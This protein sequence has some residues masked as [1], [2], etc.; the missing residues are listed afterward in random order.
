MENFFKMRITKLQLAKMIAEEIKIVLEGDKNSDGSLSPDELRDMADNMQLSARPEELKEL[1]SVVRTANQL[2]NRLSPEAKPYLIRNFQKYLDIWEKDLRSVEAGEYTDA[3][4]KAAEEIL[5][6]RMGSYRGTTLPGGE[7]I[8]E[9][10][11]GGDVDLIIKAAQ[12]ASGARYPITSEEAF[13]QAVDMAHGSPGNPF[14][15]MLPNPNEIQAAWY[16]F[17]RRGLH[18]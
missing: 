1:E 9:M 13:I 4:H 3:D 7:R 6:T 5:S 17:V 18:R 15:R 16:E 8:N 14:G 2:F 11:G 12:D 10:L